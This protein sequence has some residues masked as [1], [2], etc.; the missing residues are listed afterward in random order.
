MDPLY[1]IGSITVIKREVLTF[2]IAG[3]SPI[4]IVVGYRAGEIEHQL[5]DY[6]VIFI[7]NQNYENTDKFDSVKYIDCILGGPFQ[8]GGRWQKPSV[9]I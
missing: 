7:R 9:R 5:S 4:V 8:Q 2:Q 1:K 3:L 6:G